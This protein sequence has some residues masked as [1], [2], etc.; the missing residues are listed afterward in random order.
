MAAPNS[1]IGSR[2]RLG[3]EL[4]R[5]RNRTGLTL[6]EVAEQMTCSTSK[7]SRL[8][9][10]KGIPKLPD[11]REL[12]RIYGVSSDTE[13][14]M[15]LRLVRDGRE[16]GW[17]EQLTDGV[18]PEPRVLDAQGRYV[19]LENDATA[20]RSFEITLVHGLLQTEAY[21]RAV[22]APLLPH[23]PDSELDRLVELRRLRQAALQR[24]DP[25]PVEL[26]AVVDEA[27]LRRVVGGREVMIGQLE[28]LY[29]ISVGRPNVSVQVLPFSAGLVRAHASPFVLLEIPEL[30]GSDVVYIE[31]H[32]GGER[33]LDNKA[34]IEIYRE[35]HDDAHQLALDPIESQALIKRYLD[36]YRSDREGG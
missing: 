25:A 16:H 8:E 30:L 5:L 21:M 24:I 35:I 1:P 23:H 10:G 12:M 32:G 19:A 28:H 31:A 33:Y 22:I 18:Q 11:V 4:R 29:R 7:I 3:A 6:D 17:W 13:R 27:V 15:M 26:I 9:T 2:R 34:D 14:D 36:E 20:I